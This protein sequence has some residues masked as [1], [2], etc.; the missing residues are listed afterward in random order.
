M[1]PRSLLPDDGIPFP[2]R[3]QRVTSP[4]VGFPLSWNGNASASA[5]PG[6]E[7]VASD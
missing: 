5:K 3:R 7:S 6:I 4:P 2:V 1:S